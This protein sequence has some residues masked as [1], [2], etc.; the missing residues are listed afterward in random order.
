MNV[1]ESSGWPVEGADTGLSMMGDFAGLAGDACPGPVLGVLIDGVP[2]VALAEEFGCS[3]SGWMCQV[4]DCMEAFLSECFGDP[5][6]RCW[7]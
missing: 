3:S 1:A 6:S 7:C 5:G 2:H 4:V